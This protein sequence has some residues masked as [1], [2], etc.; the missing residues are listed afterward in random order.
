MGIIRDLSGQRYGRLTVVSYAG[1]EPKH[2]RATWNCRCDCGKEIVVISNKLTGGVTQSCGCLFLE[3]RGAGNRTHGETHTRLY[4]IWKGMRHRCYSKSRREYPSY[5]GRGIMVCPEWR[6]DFLAFRDWAMANGY[7][8]TLSIDR[9]DN[10]GNYEPANCRWAD[11]KQQNNNRRSNRPITYSGQT[12]T[13][14]EWS[15]QTGIP[16]HVLSQRLGRMGWSVEKALTTPVDRR[17]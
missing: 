8:D 5:G 12:M 1:K 9:I 7:D 10:D 3:R 14:T 4:T 6:D 16:F 17:G 2:N 11:T 15:E 13:I